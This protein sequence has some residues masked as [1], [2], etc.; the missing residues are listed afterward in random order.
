MMLRQQTSPRENYAWST[1]KLVWG[2]YDAIIE[3]CKT[4]WHFLINDLERIRSI[5]TRECACVDSVSV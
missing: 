2:S 5:G 3:A 1:R 4:A